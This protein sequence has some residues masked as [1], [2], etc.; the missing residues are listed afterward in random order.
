MLNAVKLLKTMPACM[1]YLSR[2]NGDLLCGAKQ[3]MVQGANKLTELPWTG[4]EAA[5]AVASDLPTEL[6][7]AAQLAG[8]QVLGKMQS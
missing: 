4:L 5:T 7:E 2:P 3:S 8:F 6:L 1:I